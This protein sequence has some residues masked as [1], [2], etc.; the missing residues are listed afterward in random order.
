MLMSLCVRFPL[1]M[2][3]FLFHGNLYIGVLR[4]VMLLLDLRKGWPFGTFCSNYGNYARLKMNRGSLGGGDFNEVLF[5]SEKIGGRRMCGSM[6]MNFPECCH[7]I[8][9]QSIRNT[10]PAWTWS[11]GRK[12]SAN[13][14]QKLDRFLVNTHWQ[15]LFPRVISNNCG[16][17]GSDHRAVKFSLNLRRWVAK[18]LKNNQFVFENK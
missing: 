10:G 7:S 5:D 13:I 6:L 15:T 4:G 18:G 17:F 8:G 14:K 1:I 11:N 16:F 3:M 12:G 9:V 2:L